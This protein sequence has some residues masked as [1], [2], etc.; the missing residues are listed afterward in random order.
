VIPFLLTTCLVP[1]GWEFTTYTTCT[2]PTLFTPL[3][4]T[5][6][7]PATRFPLPHTIFSP[8]FTTSGSEVPRDFPPHLHF[9]LNSSHL[10]SGH[11]WDGGSSHH[12]HGFSTLPSHYLLPATP[13]WA[14]TGRCTF[15]PHWVSWVPLHTTPTHCSWFTA[16]TTH[17]TTP[18]LPTYWEVILFPPTHYLSGFYTTCLHSL[19][20]PTHLFS[21]TTPDGPGFCTLH[22]CTWF[23]HWAWVPALHG[24][25]VHL[26]PPAPT[27][28]LHHHGCGALGGASLLHCTHLHLLSLPSCCI[29]YCTL[30]THTALTLPLRTASHYL[31]SFGLGHSLPHPHSLTT[32]PHTTHLSP[33]TSFPALVF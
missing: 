23:L 12:S 4:C 5:F 10:D 19:H 6:P 7:S 14:H 27:A 21:P 9:L 15:S 33:S 3:H 28:T 16:P 11:T 30:C 25:R 22:T 13:P 26:P 17:T 8:P 29:A 31:P 20:T 24:P 2:L 18:A 1:T 32:H